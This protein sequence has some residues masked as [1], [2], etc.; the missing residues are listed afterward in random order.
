MNAA[1]AL[2]EIGGTADQAI[3]RLAEM[4]DDPNSRVVRAVLEAIAC[5]GSNT[6]AALPAL[7]KLLRRDRSSWNEDMKLAFLPGDQVHV[8]AVQAL[9]L[10]DIDPAEVEDLMVE[11]LAKPSATV[12]VPTIALE[13]LVRHGSDKSMRHAISYLQAHRWDDM[14][15][16]ADVS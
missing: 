3:P 15:R 7:E 10:S 6:K 5:I 2:G 11:L 14:K 9:L 12:A 1:F 16:P 8:S 4:L 13:F